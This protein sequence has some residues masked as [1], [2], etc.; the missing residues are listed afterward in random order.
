MM[1]A[2]NLLA[3]VFTAFSMGSRRAKVYQ[4]LILVARNREVLMR[5]M[6]LALFGAAGQFCIYSAI[7]NLGPVYFTWIMMARQ[8]LSVLLS[9]VFFGHGTSAIQIICI[10]MVFAVMSF[11][12]LNELA[13]NILSSCSKASNM[14]PTTIGTTKR[15]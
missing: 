11:K 1:L 12:H 10:F 4:S 3:L 9:L 15:D 8:L 14:K 13:G 7:K 2:G 6:S 5:V